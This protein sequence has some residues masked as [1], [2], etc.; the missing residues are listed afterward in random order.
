M[1]SEP[2]LWAV[3]IYRFGQH[4]HETSGLRGRVGRRVYPWLHLFSRAFLQIEIP[5]TAQIG[6]G[7]LIFH[8][9]PI[10][11]NNSVR[12]GARCRLRQGVTI[13]VSERGGAAP[14][15]GDD[16]F[17]G[18]NAQILG[19]VTVGDGATV[20]AGAVVTRDVAPAATVGGVPAKPIGS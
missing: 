18:S 6:P 14:T 17:V 20:A 5:H 2:G 10:V 11:I 4:V 9:G 3:A 12:I 7:L 13:G 8:Q 19:G 15:L 1:R 16:V